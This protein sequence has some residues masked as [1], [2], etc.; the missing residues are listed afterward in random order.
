MA[1]LANLEDMCRNSTL[2]S[3]GS[4]GVG[5]VSN[6]GYEWNISLKYIFFGRTKK[7]RVNH[8]ILGYIA[9]FLSKLLI[10]IFLSTCFFE[11]KAISE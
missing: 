6:T 10:C 8:N 7:T 4:S 5:W 1:L 9:T 2:A 3:P 11:L